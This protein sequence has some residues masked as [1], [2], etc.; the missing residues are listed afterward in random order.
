MKAKD[1]I[2]FF[3]PIKQ[4]NCHENAV[5]LYDGHTID[6]CFPGQ[7]LALHPTRALGRPA[8]A[9]ALLLSVLTP[10]TPP[11]TAPSVAADPGACAFACL[12]FCLHCVPTGLNATNA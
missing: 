12:A 7:H 9:A 10:A 11:S 6:L 3:L 2:C 4:Q 1:N 8:P 5:L